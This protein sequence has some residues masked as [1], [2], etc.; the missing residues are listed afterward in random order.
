MKQND[1]GEGEKREVVKKAAKGGDREEDDEEKEEQ[2]GEGDVDEEYDDDGDRV[3]DTNA[4]QISRGPSWVDELR[5]ILQVWE[6]QM[7][8]FE[9]Q[10]EELK[11]GML[12]MYRNEWEQ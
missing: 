5:N 10:L 4:V 11:R 8:T 7:G 3:A 2:E 12:W 6:K 9:K 1:E